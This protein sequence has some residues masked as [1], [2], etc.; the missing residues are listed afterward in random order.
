MPWITGNILEALNA[1]ESDGSKELIR[2]SRRECPGMSEIAETDPHAVQTFSIRHM[3]QTN[4]ALR[5]NSECLVQN[6]E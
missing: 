2:R 1:G 3:G 5:E 4:P 6:L